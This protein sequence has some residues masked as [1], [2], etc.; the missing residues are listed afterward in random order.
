MHIG[1]FLDLMF[2]NIRE[3]PKQA[4]FPDIINQF[5]FQSTILQIY[6]ITFI[7]A[8]IDY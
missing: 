3:L 2:K 4:E 1:M 5:P 8:F 6:E 7:T